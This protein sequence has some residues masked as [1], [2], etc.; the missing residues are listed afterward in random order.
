[1]LL[2][3]SVVALSAGATGA[4][5]ADFGNDHMRDSGRSHGGAA[6]TIGF[7]D[8][9]FGYRDGYWDNG[10]QWHSWSNNTAFAR[11]RDHGTN[12]HGWNHTRDADHG[13]QHH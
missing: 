9:A 6:V 3:V 7:D 11:Y 4:A 12:Y 8:V 5:A 13:W 1:M 2:A 10:H